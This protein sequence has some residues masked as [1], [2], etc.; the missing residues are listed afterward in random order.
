MNHRIASI[1]NILLIPFTVAVI[2]CS[3]NFN[4]GEGSFERAPSPSSSQTQSQTSQPPAADQA[5]AGG[6]TWTAP[7][8]WSVGAPRTMRIV[9]YGISAE[10]G[11]GE[12]AECAVFY[13]GPGQG[14]TVRA[15]LQRWYGQFEQPDGRPS[16]EAAQLQETTVDGIKITVVEVSGTY[17]SSA[18]PMSPEKVKKP[19]FRML[20]GIIEGPQ[21]PVFFKLT[22]PEKTVARAAEEFEALVKSVKKE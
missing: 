14:G 7:P 12:D 11:D 8:R 21:G 1:L 2:A 20:G 15:N 22:G 3:Q 18:A 19:N 4:A 17:L 10:E 5:S 9:T 13:F 16:S 6:L